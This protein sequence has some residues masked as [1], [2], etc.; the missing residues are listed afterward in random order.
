M[1]AIRQELA[2]KL[3]V[4][5]KCGVALSAPVPGNQ[6]VEFGAKVNNIQ[7]DG[8]S[9]IEH[10]SFGAFNDGIRLKECIRLQQKLIPKEGKGRCRRFHLCHQCKPQILYGKTENH[11]LRAQGTGGQG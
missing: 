11:L 6:V 4:V 2:A 9:F 8:N 7:V 5:G 1:N 3:T 10:L